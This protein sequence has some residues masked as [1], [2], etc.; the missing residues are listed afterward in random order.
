MNGDL[1]SEAHTSV[2]SRATLVYT[3]IQIAFVLRMPFDIPSAQSP[4]TQHERQSR[5]L[6]H[7]A[8]KLAVRKC[9]LLSQPSPMRSITMVMRSYVAIPTSG[10]QR[11]SEGGMNPTLQTS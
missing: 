1:S 4:F 5:S 9:R 10:R 3:L 2:F 11:L 8:V 7:L 6:T